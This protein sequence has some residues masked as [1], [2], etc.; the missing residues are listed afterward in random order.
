[1]LQEKN[2]VET[3]PPTPREDSMR[4]LSRILAKAAAICLG[5]AP[6][7]SDPAH[8]QSTAQGTIMLHG[9]V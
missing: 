2:P 4:F 7:P 3:N 5:A 6:F 1:M 8:A 9:A